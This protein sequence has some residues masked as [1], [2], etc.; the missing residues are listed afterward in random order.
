VASQAVPAGSGSYPVRDTGPMLPGGMP[1]GPDGFYL[2]WYWAAALAGGY[3]LTVLWYRRH[4]R[5]AGVRTR[6]AAT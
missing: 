3:L 5:R 4:A 1:S 6:P 2:G